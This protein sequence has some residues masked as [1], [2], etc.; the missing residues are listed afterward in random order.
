MAGSPADTQAWL[1]KR[2]P[3]IPPPRRRQSIRVEH[4][5]TAVLPRLADLSGWEDDRQRN[6]LQRWSVA[7]L[8]SMVVNLAAMV[9]AAL[10]FGPVHQEGDPPILIAG[11]AVEAE[12]LEAITEPVDSTP[13]EIGIAWQSRGTRPDVKEIVERRNQA[14]APIHTFAYE[15][16]ES[17][18]NMEILAQMTGGEYKY[19]PPADNGRTEQ[20]RQRFRTR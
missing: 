3:A 14:N 1:S 17:K 20:G 16:P 15:A 18:E 6:L 13:G 11:F 8:I 12:E 4:C 9:M 7:W 10:I 19:L 2:P 5:R